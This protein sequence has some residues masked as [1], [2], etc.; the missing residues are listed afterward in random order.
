MNGLGSFCLEII[1][2]KCR[3]FSLFVDEFV[4][5]FALLQLYSNYLVVYYHFQNIEVESNDGSHVESLDALGPGR[6][7]FKKMCTCSL[8]PK[9]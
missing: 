1:T 5:H 9:Q 4:S 8:R 3:P 2:Y 6:W 7:I